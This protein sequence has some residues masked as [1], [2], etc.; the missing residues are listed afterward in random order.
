MR[1][2]TDEEIRGRLK[3]TAKDGKISCSEALAVA[4]ELKVPSKKVGAL[5]D[6]MNVR[7]VKCQLGCFE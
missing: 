1:M 5:L 4:R 2:A 6:D 3:K 7:I